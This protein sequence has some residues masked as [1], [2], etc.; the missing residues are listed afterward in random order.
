MT[1]SYAPVPDDLL[2]T[3]QEWREKMVSAAA[4]ASDELMDKYLE[5]GDLDE[6]EIIA[7]LRKRT[8]AGEIQPMLCGSAFK[9]KGCSA[10]SMR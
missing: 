4:E 5:T 8:V 3:A 1:F 6:A 9:N 2:A 7:G 10:C